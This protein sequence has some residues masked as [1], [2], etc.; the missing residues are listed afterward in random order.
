LYTCAGTGAVYTGAEKHSI[1]YINEGTH[2]VKQPHLS[3][4]TYITIA[5]Q[6]RYYTFTSAPPDTS[7]ISVE[8]TAWLSYKAIA[9]IKFSLSLRLV[10]FN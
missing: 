9:F 3:T 2:A 6:S 5:L 4:T 8:V 10:I 1:I 7:Y